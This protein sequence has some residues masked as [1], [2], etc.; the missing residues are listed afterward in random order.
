MTMK[1]K[2]PVLLIIRMSALGDVAMTIPA[3]YSLAVQY[4]QYR[5]KVLTRPFFTRLF[6]NAPGNISFI[7]TDR[8]IHRGIRG[9][10]K[11]IGI[12]GK[13]KIDKVADF[14]NVLRSWCI[15]CYFRIT[16]KPVSIVRKQ[17]SKRKALTRRRNKSPIAQRNYIL[18]YFDVLERLGLPVTPT[19]RS[20]FQDI[21]PIPFTLDIPVP[22]GTKWIGI[23]PF[24]RYANKTYP[25]EQMQEVVKLLTAQKRYTIFLFGGGEKETAVLKE[26]EA[27][28]PATI[29]LPG[30][31]SLEQELSLMSRLKV[32][33]S[34]D[35]A[36][37]HLASLTGT[38]VISIWGS[39]TPLCGF[40]GWGQREDNAIVAGTDCQ[41][42]SI[43]GAEKCPLRH[44]DCMNRITP[45]R[46]FRQIEKTL[47]NEKRTL[48]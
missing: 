8:D 7:T 37:M 41:P 11:L 15:D 18:R 23:A 3:I 26:W 47:L 12:L 22:S 30:R 10:L 27:A 16:G 45:E 38:P 13:E 44:F 1:K 43:S 35:S 40:G 39:T 14:H 20:I 21:P 6:V 46:I 25:L 9:V 33:V 48:C 19:F 29:A 4:P 42:C 34:M 5:I 28:Y 36:N 24:A 2:E 32:M 31:L 17:R